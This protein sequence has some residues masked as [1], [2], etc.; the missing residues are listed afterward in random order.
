MTHSTT[1]RSWEESLEL[2]KQNVSTDTHKQ[3]VSWAKQKYSEMK[4]AR[5]A[6][7]RQWYFNLSMFYGKQY[8]DILRT[9]A[10]NRLM[11]TPPQARGTVRHT[12]NLIRPLIR[13]EI[14]RMTSQK[15]TATATPATS[16]DDDM[17]AAQ[18]AE[19][20]W[21]FLQ[22]AQNVQRKQRRNAFWT[23]ITGN[24]FMKTYWDAEYQK[25]TAALAEPDLVNQIAPGD[26]AIGDVRIDVVT[27]F[28]L[29]VPD[30]LVEDIED[31]PY[32][33]EAYTR[34]VSWV[35]KFWPELDGIQPDVVSRNE[36]IETS[37]FNVPG[38]D[39]ARPDAVL[40]MECWIKPGGTELLPDGGMFIVVGDHIVQE[41]LEGMPYSHEEY[42]YAKFEHIPSGKFYADSVLVD[43]NNLQREYNRT[44]SQI[45][46]SK[47]KMA[48]PQLLA[49]EGSLDTTRI[50]AQPGLIIK[51]KMGFPAPTPMQM[52]QLPAYVLQ[53]QDRIKADIED[54]SAQHQVTRGQAPG[55]GITAATAISFL[56]EKDDSIMGPTYASIEEGMEKIARQAISLAVDYYDLARVIE[57]VGLDK[58]F[59]SLELKGADIARGK[60]I[61]ME[62]GSALPTSKAARQAL[63]MDLVKM[64]A[65]PP[66]EML[67]MLEIGGVDRIVNR[68]RIDMRQAQRE[69]LKMKKLTEEDIAAYEQELIEGGD[70]F[71][72]MTGLPTLLVDTPAT[73]PP[74]VPVNEFDNHM[75]HI[76][77]HNDYRKTQEFDMLSDEVKHQFQVHVGLH[78]QAIM[79]ST[80]GPGGSLVPPGMDQPPMGEPGG[81]EGQPGE[82]EQPGPGGPLPPA[83]SP[84][85]D[86]EFNAPGMEGI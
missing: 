18:A 19:S 41:H 37:Y 48:R 31:Q 56:Q 23:A 46:E 79:M 10:G 20:T 33:I 62:A 13:S 55:S 78:Q 71:D 83:G 42:P 24:G 69:N 75:V 9:P 53:E 68:I 54:I 80:M 22:R 70:Q 40:V 77:V 17:F 2:S 59:D 28:N 57:F 25:N 64:G 12:V 61:R 73:Y 11:S 86:I 3:L 16:S 81:G 74:I 63:L 44:R 47:N 8:L 36:I 1:Q 27:P 43:I 34:P 6:T 32:V 58:S 50:T 52:P 7:V 39:Q 84:E 15:P 66:E 67:E 65:I 26:P 51:Y 21:D 30:L 72:P 5:S 29:F 82:P 4:Q 49:A 60:N 35:K 38:S 14:A 85:S 76:Q 45:I